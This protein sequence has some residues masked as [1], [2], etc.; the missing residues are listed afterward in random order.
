MY[1]LKNQVIERIQSY[2][3]QLAD[4]YLGL[5]EAV[6]G[7]EMKVLLFH[8][9]QFER[10]RHVYLEKHRKIAQAMNCWLRVPEDKLTA[11]ISACFQNIH[12]GPD[13][14]MSQLIDMELHFDD[15]LTRLYGILCKEDEPCETVQNVFYYMLKK[16]REDEASLKEM[17]AHLQTH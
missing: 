15:C 14:S 10:D 1:M 2:H 4:L 6:E 17:F 13:L 5:Y 9:H 16:T 8:L 3:G 12:T 11:Q 7:P